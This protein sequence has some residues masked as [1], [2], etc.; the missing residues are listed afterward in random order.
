MVGIM[1][2]LE[3]MLL[4]VSKH[5]D[6]YKNRIKEYEIKDPLDITQWP[7]LTR[8]ELQENRYN[9]FSDGYKA[10]YFNQ[11]LIRQLSSGSTGMPVNVYWDHKDW[12]ASNVSLWRK[13]KKN[14]E[15]NPVDKY[16]T[17]IL[18]AFGVKPEEERLYYINKPNNI[19]SF[20]ISLIL[21][22]SGYKRVI[23]LINEFK[24][25]WL[26]IQ[27]FVLNQLICAYKDLNIQPVKSIRYIESVG[28]IL[29]SD[30]RRKAEEFFDF[31]ITNMYGSE[32]MNGIAYESSKGNLQVI[33]D[34]V[35]VEVQNSNCIGCSGTGETI[36]TNLNNYAMPLI[37]YNQGDIVELNTKMPYYDEKSSVIDK[38]QGRTMESIVVGNGIELNSFLLCE[39]M[40]EVNNQFDC[41]IESYRYVYDKLNRNLTCLFRLNKSKEK[42]FFNVRD[43]ILYIW[44]KK[45]F[46]D[47]INISVKIDY[48][49]VLNI[50]KHKIL[51][52]I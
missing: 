10:K 47:Y 51:E 25:D 44:K 28:E 37:R 19:M 21:D 34:N 9:M 4:Y 29:T 40:S 13:R 6:F 30:L 11:L 32:E 14:Y 52:I 31:G 1:T 36:I 23:K 15:I 39:I 43:L 22:E 41:V 38:I 27:P 17:F 46:T 5:N 24:P 12:Y 18:N 16:C 33:E 8:K 2:K 3:K 26:Y 45:R 50:D 35:F 48:D 42:W 20:N 7:V 49:D